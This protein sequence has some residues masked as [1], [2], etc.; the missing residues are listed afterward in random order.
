M[1]LAIGVLTAFAPLPEFPATTHPILCWGRVNYEPIEDGQILGATRIWILGSAGLTAD[2]LVS[3]MKTCELTFSM[4]AH[5]G[6]CV[7]E[8]GDI[9]FVRFLRA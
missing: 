7:P 9:A 3:F 4:L 1:S 5:P 6:Q 2:Q 8:R